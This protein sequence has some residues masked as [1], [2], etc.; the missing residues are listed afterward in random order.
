MSQKKKFTEEEIKQITTFN[1]SISEIYLKLGQLRIQA[2]GVSAQLQKNESELMEQFNK[3][4]TDRDSY[5][6]TLYDKYGDGTFDPIS[7]EFTP[8]DSNE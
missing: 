8:T 6:K 2:E 1:N 4:N 3:L 7:G 5:F